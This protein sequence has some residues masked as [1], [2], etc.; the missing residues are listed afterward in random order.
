M[1]HQSKRLIISD[2]LL[3]LVIIFLNIMDRIRNLSGVIYAIVSSATFGLIPLFTIPLIDNGISSPS[4]LCYRFLIAAAAMG[5]IVLVA[6][7]RLRLQRSEWGVVFLLSLLYAATAILL[8]ES[9]K[10]IPSGIATT[11]H[12]LYPLAVTLTMSLFFRVKVGS[13]TYLAIVVSLA[14]VT[15]LAWG[16]HTDGDFHHGVMIA[17]TTV[18]TYAAY[19]VGVMKSRAA[20]ID[21]FTL[22]FYVLLF[23]AGIFF[24]YAI[25]TTGI[26]MIKGGASWRNIIMVALVSTVLSDLSLVIAIK[27]IGSITTSILGSMEPLT[28]VVIGVLYFGEKLDMKSVTGLILIIIAVIMVILSSRAKESV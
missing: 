13:A 15:L 12:F 18:V 27:R 26:E 14:G 19:I 9:Y 5:I 10:F 2:M 8:I 23:G 16:N 4:I 6:G 7:N 28:A 22:T 24:I 21:S 20:H 17:L 1:S 11:I 25:T 3:L